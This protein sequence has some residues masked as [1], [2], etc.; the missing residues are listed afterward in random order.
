MVAGESSG[1]LLGSLLLRSLRQRW[2]D[3]KAAGIGGP[4]MAEQGFQC[5]WPSE[6]L[7]VR[8]YVEVLPRYAE[9]LRMRRALA[10]RLLAQRPGIFIGIDAPDFN[11]DL[12]QRLRSA[13]VKTIQFVS[14]AFWAWRAKKLPKLKEA[15]DLVLCIFP[16]E[17]ALLEQRGIRARFVGHPLAELIPLQP[18]TDAARQALGLKGGADWVALLPGSRAAEVRQLA[19][20]FLA[21]A[22]ILAAAKPELRFVLPAVPAEFEFLSALISQSV[23]AD[24]VVLL[25]GQ[26]HAA[27][28][29]CDLALVA[30]GTA[31]L[32]AALFKKPMVIAYQMNWLSW[33]LTQRKRLQPWVGLP[34]I[35]CQEM[36]VPELLQHEATPQAIADAALALLDDPA[37]VEALRQRFDQLHG[38]LKRDTSRLCLDAIEELCARIPS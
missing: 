11:L 36:L 2:P 34:N 30:S 20:R 22:E 23:L 21:A 14:P 1:D 6:R 35:L 17:P 26:S 3:L 28:A 7:A 24:K 37:R 29:A 5:W 15:A 12:E 19:P 10:E 8:G 25:R 27:L 32:E 9:L 31:T 33:A 16:F 4:A 18:Q 38:E 13:G